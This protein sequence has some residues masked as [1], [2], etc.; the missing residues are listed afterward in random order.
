MP[1]L[2]DNLDTATY[3]YSQQ[4]DPSLPMTQCTLGTNCS[5]PANGYFAIK[6]PVL[7]AEKKSS[8]GTISTFLNIDIMSSNSEVLGN[9]SQVIHYV[10]LKP[11]YLALYIAKEHLTK[12]LYLAAIGRASSLTSIQQVS[13]N[14]SN[15]G[16]LDGTVNFSN[17]DNEAKITGTAGGVIYLPKAISGKIYITDNPNGFVTSNVPSEATTDIPFLVYE[18]TFNDTS[19]G[20]CSNSTSGSI[21]CQSLFFDQSYVNSF[22]MPGS[23]DMMGAAGDKNNF[24]KQS[25]AIDQKRGFTT[26]G[27]ETSMSA[28][29]DA[30]K[31]KTSKYTHWSSSDLLKEFAGKTGLL[32][33]ISAASYNKDGSPTSSNPFPTGYY[34]P[35]TSALWTYIASHPIYVR[36]KGATYGT[37]CVAK[38]S[39]V[40]NQLVF[41]QASGHYDAETH[42]INTNQP[43][44]IACKTVVRSLDPKFSSYEDTLQSGQ[45]NQV[46]MNQL[47]ACDFL[48]GAGSSLCH[49]NSSNATTNVGAW[50]PNGTFRAWIGETLVS[51]QAIGLLPTCQN[52]PG[53]GQHYV[54]GPGL[55]SNILDTTTDGFSNPSCLNLPA[56]SSPTYNLYVDSLRPYVNVYTYSYG[57]FL[58]LDGT[59]SYSRNNFP[60][61]SGLQKPTN[62]YLNQLAFPQPI[63]ITIRSSEG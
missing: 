41:T 11:G 33:P 15:T 61:A 55:A 7:A 12:T 44:N 25:F 63:S 5:V 36:L 43:N 27:Q 21:Y 38:G 58:G 26:R 47:N 30:Y 34:Q 51:F 24:Q 57:D 39:I 46:K 59:V 19:G 32:A 14:G 9:Y 20:N 49:P 18:Y 29:I 48:Q 50:G 62:D 10:N 23:F 8:N 35:Y 28:I 4:L 1:G 52:A 6:L 22:F 45:A 17:P 56:G 53:N 16:T 13:F 42:I 2:V 3:Y 60:P 54:L 31:S 37:N 40:N